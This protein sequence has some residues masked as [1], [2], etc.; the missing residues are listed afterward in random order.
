MDDFERLRELCLALD[1]A[2]AQQ[3]PPPQD[4]IER[5]IREMVREAASYGVTPRRLERD[6]RRHSDAFWR[7]WFAMDAAADLTAAHPAELAEVV[8]YREFARR[9]DAFGSPSDSRAAS[10]ESAA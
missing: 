2:A 4:Q 10:E 5:E 7:D 6:A 3:A 1:A 8:Y 9:H